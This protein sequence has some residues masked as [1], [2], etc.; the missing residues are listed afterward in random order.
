MR[1]AR[2]MLGSKLGLTTGLVVGMVLTTGAMFLS[3]MATVASAATQHASSAAEFRAAANSICRTGTDGRTQELLKHFPDGGK[4]EP[5]PAQIAAFVKDYKVVVQHQIDALAKLQPPANLKPKLTKLV[6]T[7]RKALAKVTAK[8]TIL[9]AGTDP[10]A[11]VTKQSLALGLTDC[12][13]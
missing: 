6:A 7:A 2:S 5:T 10:F 11:S 12:A 1:R 9:L 13:N 4:K 3:P 8:P